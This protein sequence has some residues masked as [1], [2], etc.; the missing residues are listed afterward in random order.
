MRTWGRDPATFVALRMTPKAWVGSVAN[1]RVRAYSRPRP[2]CA[3][4][5][6]HPANRYM[7]HTLDTLSVAS[8]RCANHVF[9]A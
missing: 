4:A 2:T 7:L 5:E 1:R 6:G 9:V 8:L 3:S